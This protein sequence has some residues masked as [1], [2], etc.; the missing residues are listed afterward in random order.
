[1]RRCF[2]VLPVRL[3]I[4]VGM[5]AAATAAAAQSLTYT[6]SAQLSTGKYVFARTT[7]SLY[8]ANGLA[9]TTGRF[10][11]SLSIPVI[12]QDAGWVQYSGG[13]LVATGGMRD[14]AGV[15][16]RGGMGDGMMS[17]QSEAAHA[18]IGIGDPVARAEA[19][20]LPGQ[21][22]IRSLRLVATAKAPVAGV[23]QGFGTGEWDYGGGLALASVVRGTFIF[24]DA[25]YWHLGDSPS[26]ELRDA[27]WYGAAV[28]RPLSDG[29]VALVASFTGS[30]R[31][32]D[33]VAAPIQAGAGVSYRWL[34]G[35]TLSVFAAVGMTAS[36]PD[37]S[38][39]MG[40]QVPLR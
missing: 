39:G 27:L 12:L 21:G 14:E 23:D 3:A 24:A 6:G 22:S 29:R 5:T 35:R 7:T 19:E 10:R 30:T 18:E 1:M 40:W 4:I 8:V 17:P 37:V 2:R 28:G 36:A 25:T 15:G 34:S 20:L 31:V 33:G 13:G 38:L 9:L 32:L 11:W 26:L 16:G